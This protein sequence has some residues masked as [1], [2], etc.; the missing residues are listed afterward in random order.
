MSQTAQEYLTK[1]GLNLSSLWAYQEKPAPFTP[2][3]PLFWDDPHISKGMLAAHLDPT[4]DCASRR[5]ETIDATVAWIMETLGLKAGDSVLDLGCGPGL[6]TMRFARAGL[7]VTGVDTS[8]RSVAYARETAEEAGLDI[9]YRYQN[10]LTLT[11]EDQY[12]AAVLIFGD[13]CPLNPDQRAKLLGHVHRALRPGGYF[14]LDVSTRSHREKYGAQNEWYISGS[15]FW[16]PEPHLVLE[17]GFD[18]P[19]EKI[20][21]DQMIV[22]IQSGGFKVYRNWFQ[23]YDPAMITRELEEGGFAV[24]SLWSDLTGTPYHDGSEWIG[25]VARSRVG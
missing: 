24:Q 3:E 6:Y 23:D 2:G 9:T 15:G 18:Y 8:R 1:K 25:V 21:L 16:S 4:T 12:D 10:Y 22:I 20:Y 17:M 13:Y 7:N 11:D 19:E 5:P 14:V